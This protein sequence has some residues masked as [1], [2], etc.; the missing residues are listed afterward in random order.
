MTEFGNLD[1]ETGKYTHV[2][3]LPQSRM[4]ACPHFIMDPIH[5][6]EEG[7]CRC[8][9]IEHTEMEAWGYEWNDANERWE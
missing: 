4:Q 3:K 6:T 8:R 5:Y 2:R 9:D 7:S 1:P